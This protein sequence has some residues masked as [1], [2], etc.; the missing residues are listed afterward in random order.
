MSDL[1]TLSTF[2]DTRR[3]VTVTLSIEARAPVQ[4]SMP[5]T[6]ALAVLQAVLCR[7]GASVRAVR[8]LSAKGVFCQADA[9]QNGH[10]PRTR[11]VF[12]NAPF[13]GDPESRAL[14]A[15]LD[16]SDVTAMAP[17]PVQSAPSAFLPRVRARGLSRQAIAKR[18]R[19]AQQV[20]AANEA[21]AARVAAQST[22]TTNS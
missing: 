1:D 12:Y 5:G 18:R 4:A 6:L 10:T 17:E 19:K 16:S 22:V 7:P 8:P 15:A 3:S 14:L 11:A 21:A 20:S 9:P 13:S 2:V